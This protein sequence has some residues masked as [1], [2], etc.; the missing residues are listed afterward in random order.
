MK[1]QKLPAGL[2][3]RFRDT[4]HAQTRARTHARTNYAQIHTR[5]LKGLFY[6][7]GYCSI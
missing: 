7:G 6:P 5:K 1:E 3:L 2:L 4:N